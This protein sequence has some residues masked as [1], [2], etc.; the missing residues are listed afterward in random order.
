MFQ[1]FGIVA[2]FRQ[3]PR[4]QTNWDMRNSQE[5]HFQS[6]HFCHQG[7]ILEAASLL[8]LCARQIAGNYAPIHAEKASFQNDDT[9]AVLLVDAS[10]AFNSLNRDTALQ[11][12]RHNCPS[13]ATLLINIYRGS[14]ELFVDGNVLFSEEDTTQ[15]DP[16]TMPMYALVTIPLIKHLNNTENVMQAWYAYDASASGSISS[17]C[18]W[19]N[20]Y[21]P[22]PCIWLPCQCCKNLAHN[23]GPASIACKN[24]LSGHTGQ[25][26]STS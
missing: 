14:T 19:W 4:Y 9:D 17:L 18:D 16:L 7:D 6:R 15:G 23:Q 3:M 8:Q 10:N 26:H 12:I 1:L 13:V 24:S 20:N 5:H 21:P 25:R 11:N 22:L 2:C